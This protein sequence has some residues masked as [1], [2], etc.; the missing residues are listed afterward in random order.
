ME[1]ALVVGMWRHTE[2]W[3]WVGAGA[4]DGLERNWGVE[5]GGEGEAQPQPHRRRRARTG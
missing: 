2:R 3:W 5:D 1:G 4:K